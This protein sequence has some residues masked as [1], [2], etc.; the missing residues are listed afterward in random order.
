MEEG[1]RSIFL[2]RAVLF[3]VRSTTALGLL[4]SDIQP[5]GGRRDGTVHRPARRAALLMG[6]LAYGLRPRG[7]RVHAGLTDR[8]REEATAK[9]AGTGFGQLRR[10]RRGNNGNARRSLGFAQAFARRTDSAQPCGL[11]EHWRTGANA[12]P[13]ST[14]GGHWFEPSTAHEKHLQRREMRCPIRRGCSVDGNA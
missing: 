9:L 12:R 10:P 1:G 6:G 11:S 13:G 8:A 2:C 5:R 4:H 3:G 7:C 14:A